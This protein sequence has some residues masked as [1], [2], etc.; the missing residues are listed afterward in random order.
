V[1]ADLLLAAG[2]AVAN[3]V[4]HAGAGTVELRAALVEAGVVELTVADDGTWKEQVQ[5]THRG[6]G[7]GLMRAL[8][9]EVIVERGEGAARGTVVRLRRRVDAGP[10]PPEAT[11]P[12]GT[13]AV[14]DG[15]CSVEIEHGVARVR[16]DLDLSCA[17]RI[18]AEL[19]RAG[20]HTIDLRAV[21]YLDS[22]GARML[23]ELATARGRRL[24]V[25]APPGASPR[26][27]LELSGLAAL[28][29]LREA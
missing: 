25:I 29:D 22:A 14:A 24:V 23:L 15:G 28:F 2:E 26:R 20:P 7:V 21:E 12:P 3:A 16:G 17:E 9:D 8:V 5:E 27:A 1:T 19:R 10:P 13:A 4:E 18:G 6:R 11:V